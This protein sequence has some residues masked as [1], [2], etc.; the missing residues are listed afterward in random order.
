[1]LVRTDVLGRP[2]GVFI[3]LGLTQAALALIAV[4][5]NQGSRHRPN[6]ALLPV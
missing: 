3:G 2:T 6:F 1:V 4:F 5:L